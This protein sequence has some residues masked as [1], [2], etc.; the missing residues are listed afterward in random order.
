MEW[1]VPKWYKPIYTIKNLSSI[2]LDNLMAAI[3]RLDL[4]I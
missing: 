3:N 4:F 1:N 2:L